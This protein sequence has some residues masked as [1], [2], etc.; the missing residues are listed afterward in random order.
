[1]DLSDNSIF[2]D[3]SVYNFLTYLDGSM[4][5]NVTNVLHLETRNL[6]CS[7]PTK[8]KGTLV[9]DIK[10]VDFRCPFDTLGLS[11]GNFFC[12]QECTAMLDIS[13]KTT[14]VNC[15]MK[16]L[17]KAPEIL[18]TPNDFDIE[19]NLENNFLTEIPELHRPD[20]I[21]VKKLFLAANNIETVNKGVLTS[22]LEVSLCK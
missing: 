21:N 8:Y 13:K 22:N 20:Y 3:C 18:C 6:T 15:F 1:M 2:C 5:T 11:R 4:A 12:P 17:F 19:L 7:S 16:K 14:I 9:T 10:S